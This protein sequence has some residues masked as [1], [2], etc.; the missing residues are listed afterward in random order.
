M[1]SMKK[2]VSLLLAL[3]LCLMLTACGGDA[4]DGDD[5]NNDEP[6]TPDTLED[7]VKD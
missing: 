5:G 7:L 6:D 1:K 2:H 3:V 4:G